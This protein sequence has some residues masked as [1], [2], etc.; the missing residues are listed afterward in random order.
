MTEATRRIP[1]RNTSAR[2]KPGKLSQLLA[3]GAALGASLGLVSGM[4]IAANRSAAP[5][6]VAAPAPTI[7]R[8]VVVS[9]PAPLLREIVAPAAPGPATDRTPPPVA[10]P[11]PVTESSGS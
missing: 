1:T 9:Q 6:A 7:R 4:A 5:E 10:Q 8:V 11:A 2:K 3:T